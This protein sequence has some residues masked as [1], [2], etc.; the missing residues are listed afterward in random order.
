M[1]ATPG[2]FKLTPE[3]RR[4]QDLILKYPT[5]ACYW[6]FEKPCCLE[7]ELDQAMGVMSHGEQLMVQ[8]FRSVWAGNDDSSLGLVEAAS[9]LGNQDLSV[10]TGWLN[11]PFFP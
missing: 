4:F 8:F 7:A 3:Q 6:D 11:D 5:V 9:T 2:Y 10:I 1:G